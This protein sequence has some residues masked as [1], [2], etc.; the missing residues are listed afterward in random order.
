[1][2]AGGVDTRA[3]PFVAFFLAVGWIRSARV[4]GRPGDGARKRAGGGSTHAIR[5]NP[6][7]LIQDGQ[8]AGA[9]G[10]PASPQIGSPSQLEESIMRELSLSEIQTISGGINPTARVVD[11]DS[12][13]APDKKCCIRIGRHCINCPL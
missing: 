5:L 13:S 4:S 12:T 1:V 7:S 3:D 9:T 10:A 6:C 8:T 11:A 2:L